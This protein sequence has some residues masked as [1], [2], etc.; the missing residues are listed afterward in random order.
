MI[1]YELV[2]K[3]IANRGNLVPV[4]EI[5]STP[6][7][8]V[9]YVSMFG[10]AKDVVDYYNLNI[11]PETKKKSIGGYK[12]LHYC[13]QIIIDIDNE[14]NLEG[15]RQSA[16]ALLKRLLEYG[17]TADNLRIYFSGKKGFHI[18]LPA[19]LFGGINPATDLPAQIKSYV[20]NL[21]KGLNDIDLV[22]YNTNRIIRLPNSLHKD[23]NLYKIPLYPNE[24]TD[25]SIDDI[26][27]LAVYPRVDFRP[28]KR[29]SEITVNKKLIELHQPEQKQQQEREY[30]TG[31]FFAPPTQGER[32]NTYLKQSIRLFANTELTPKEIYQLISNTNQAAPNPLPEPELKQVVKQAY[33]Y[34]KNK[35]APT[36]EERKTQTKLFIDIVPEWLESIARKEKRFSLLFEELD[37]DMRHNL[38]GKLI[39]I[40]GKGGSRKSLYSQN[41]LMYNI[42]HHGARGIYSNMEMGNIPLFSRTVDIMLESENSNSSFSLEIEELSKPGFAREVLEKHI[43]P[44][45]AD[46]FIYLESS[47]MTADDYNKILEVETERHGKIDFLVVDGLSMMGGKGSETESYSRNSKELKDLAKQWNICI[48][49]ICHVTKEARKEYRDLSPYV[50]GS[51]KILDNADAMIS[52]SQCIDPLTLT[53]DEPEYLTGKGYL[54]YYNKRGSG[55]T[56]RKIFNFNETRLTISECFDDPN[57]Y[58]FEKKKSF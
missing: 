49:L 41:I 12:G 4:S 21:T 42:I 29:L 27:M 55:R 19:E 32:N 8:F 50:R 6:R 48:P 38:E 22:I 33:S 13:N 16:I 52:L 11:D 46:K 24:L 5:K 25:L 10:Y 1:F 17:C 37:K 53:L 30:L 45:M 43:A 28:L 3:N 39:A 36:K 58:E 14:N 35:I 20:Q 23:T 7:D 34:V 15:S 47:S 40:M 9:A 57:T 54:H 18:S 26:K 56:I 31:D 44:I 51:E 2:E